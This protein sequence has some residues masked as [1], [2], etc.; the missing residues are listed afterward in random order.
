MTDA[1]EKSAEDAAEP[2]ETE[3]PA[4]TE[5]PSETQEK[6]WYD[7]ITG[8]DAAAAIKNSGSEDAFKTVL[9][10][11]YDSI[12]TKA[13]E[14]D[15]FYEGEDWTNYTIKIHAL[16]S[17]T[18][19]IGAEDAAVKAERL[20]NAGKNTD[21]DYIRAHHGEFMEEYLGYRQYLSDV[22]GKG[23]EDDS[24]NTDIPEADSYMMELLYEEFKEACENM[25][26]DMLA[27]EHHRI[28]ADRTDGRGCEE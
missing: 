26:S 2:A 6:H 18:R 25:D 24:V 21:V 9:Q 8:I 23:K 4:V 19:L 15:S 22:C 14:L 5:T 7:D 1:A 13:A 3:T 16:K 12:D 17:S 20:E 11:F 28:T 10:I 27:P